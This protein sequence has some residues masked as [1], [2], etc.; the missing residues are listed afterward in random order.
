MKTKSIILSG[1]LLLG[2]G[3]A[4]TSCEDMFEPDNNLVSTNLTPQDTVYQLMGIVQNMQKI[5]D[6]TVLLGELRGD[7][8]DVNS[9][10][11]TALRELAEGTAGL[12]NEYN[13]PAEYYNVINSC[14]IYLANVDANKMAAGKPYYRSEIIA[15]KCF[16]AWCYLELAK[17]YGNVPFILKPVLTTQAAEDMVNATDNRAGLEQI[18]DYFINDL[19]EY[20]L[21]PLNN[22]LLPF[23]YENWKWNGKRGR[24]FFIPVRL[25]LAELYLWRGSAKGQGAG[26]GDFENAIRMYHDY[27]A[28]PGEEL[29]ANSQR[30]SW[31]G[32]RNNAPLSSTNLYYDTFRYDQS[33]GGGYQFVIPMDTIGYW[34]TYSDLRSVFCAQ[35]KNNYYVAVNPSV[36]LRE[37]SRSQVNCVYVYN[38]PSNIDT[39]YVSDDVNMLPDQ[40][41]MT[42]SS[43]KEDFL[44]DLR[45][46]AVY[47]NNAAPNSKLLY[48]AEYSPEEQYI[49]KYMDGKSM[50]TT[51]QR[52]NYVGFFRTSIIYLHLAEALN[53]AGLP[54]TAFAT[55]KY[56]L[57]STV[58]RDPTKVS[59]YEYDK[60]NSI[61]SYGLAEGNTAAMW[62][63]TKF[64]TIDQVPG[65]Y[66]A[67][68]NQVSP[69]TNGLSVTQYGIHAFGSG[70]AWYNKH[71]CIPGILPLPEVTPLGD[72]PTEEELA[73]Y[74]E[75]MAAR[76]AV[77]EQNHQY[78]HEGTAAQDWVDKV[79]LEE[80]ALEG[81]FEGTRYYDLMRYALYHGDPNFVADM[82]SKRR[83]ADDQDM[84]LWNRFS[85]GK[86][87]LPLP[88]R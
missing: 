56:G 61:M 78:L 19:A 46:A 53:R 29:T 80:E 57:S 83:G 43:A 50:L 25:M 79:I 71:Y 9:H 45:F 4:T 35:M 11:P 70:D 88:T 84:S 72:D 87:Y 8:V 2:L 65:G 17:I 63:P 41:Q 40:I 48:H 1:L 31:R 13:S 7:L 12:E 77:E 58:L 28:Y 85:G 42:G 21:L 47:E 64:V 34:G 60:L 76:Q 37:I 36:R 10:T 69:S 24:Y 51:D 75:Q 22:E 54:E 67:S 66:D 6:R 32:W 38:S 49:R 86:W 18:C 16:R 33:Q 14:N 20:A 15:V 73:L 27:L 5:A 62:D 81:M 59:A 23:D 39:M 82:V 26:Q 74:E 55:L 68:G 44:G 52:Q 3:A 30:A